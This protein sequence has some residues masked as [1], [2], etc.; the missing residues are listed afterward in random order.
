MMRMRDQKTAAFR[1]GMLLVALAAIVVAGCT[2]PTEPKRAGSPNW[3][4]ADGKPSVVMTIDFGDGMEKR[5][6][7]IPH[8]DAMTVLAALTAAASHPRNQ[9]RQDRLGRSR[10][11][12]GN[13]WRRQRGRRRP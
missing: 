8:E 3:L 4:A 6:S 13:R 2:R 10:D 12:N 11:A 7:R 5:F 1:R 9:V